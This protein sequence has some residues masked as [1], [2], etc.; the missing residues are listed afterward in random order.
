M[1]LV[2]IDIFQRFKRHS[3]RYIAKHA[4]TLETVCMYNPLSRCTKALCDAHSPQQSVMEEILRELASL[5]LMPSTHRL[6]GRPLR[7]LPVNRYIAKPTTHYCKVHSRLHP[8]NSTMQQH[9]IAYSFK[10][11]RYHPEDSPGQGF[12]V[13]KPHFS[14][15]ERVPNELAIASISSIPYPQ[16]WRH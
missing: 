16:I 2:T 6:A 5:H 11:R 7:R 1:V 4:R 10:S 9:Q 12:H 8:A 13:I 3:N 14:V 15:R